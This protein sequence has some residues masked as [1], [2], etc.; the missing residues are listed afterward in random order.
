MIINR[1][2]LGLHLISVFLVACWFRS[3]FYI[4]WCFWLGLSFFTPRVFLDGIYIL[5]WS[6]TSKEFQGVYMSIYT[7]TEVNYLYIYTYY[8]LTISVF[9]LN[10][11]KAS[12]SCSIHPKKL[13]Y[14]SKLQWKF[15][16]FFHD[17]FLLFFISFS[18]N[19]CLSF[20]VSDEGAMFSFSD[21]FFK[22]QIMRIQMII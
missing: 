6:H 8:N 7:P 4:N 13:L 22:T 11:P 17:M 12:I 10:P 9:T 15:K 19:E 18:E 1:P 16:M 20:F 5:W 21:A 14:F 3:Y 2:G